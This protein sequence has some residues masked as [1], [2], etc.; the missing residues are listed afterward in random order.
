M[1]RNK[2]T[3]LSVGRFFTVDTQRNY[4]DQPNIDLETLGRELGV[5]NPWE[6]VTSYA[7]PGRA[8]A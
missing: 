5:L 3:E 7:E 4:V 2:S 6:V 8:Q 1:A